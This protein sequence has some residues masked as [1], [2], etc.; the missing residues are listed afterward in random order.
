MSDPVKALSKTKAT[1]LVR[2]VRKALAEQLPAVQEL[3]QG[4]AWVALGYADWQTL[5]REEFGGPLMLPKPQRV[6]AVA[7]MSETG[8]SNRAIGET[9]GVDE[10]TVRRDHSGAANAAPEQK[11][12]GKDGKVYTRTRVTPKVTKTGKVEA[13]PV[14]DDLDDIISKL[15]DVRAYAERTDDPIAALRLS[16]LTRG[17]QGRKANSDDVAALIIDAIHGGADRL[18]ISHAALEGC[19]AEQLATHVADVELLIR[20]AKAIKPKRSTRKGATVLRGAR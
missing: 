1:A 14:E 19:T 11:C 12:L 15:N 2:Q 7:M 10:T 3:Y 8:M 13:T 4:Q 9:L 17:L 16:I 20:D 6:E 5:I 18:V